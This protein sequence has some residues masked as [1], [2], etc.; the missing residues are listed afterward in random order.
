MNDNDVETI[1]AVDSF[2]A[3]YI[4]K[5]IQVKSPDNCLEFAN[6]MGEISTTEPSGTPAFTNLEVILKI[7]ENILII[8]INKNEITRKI[9]GID[10]QSSRNTRN[11]FLQF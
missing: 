5:L 2:N 4:Y 7:A 11:K 3:G 1:G 8:T 6:L 10:R 9:I